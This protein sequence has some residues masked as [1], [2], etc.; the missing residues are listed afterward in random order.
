MTDYSERGNPDW[1]VQKT[2][3]IDRHIPATRPGV[4]QL[5]AKYYL[6][7]ELKCVRL[8]STSRWF[9][10][11]LMDQSMLNH[12]IVVSLNMKGCICH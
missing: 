9:N 2:D 12:N 10:G 5:L 4:V 7:G 1:L 11:D 3:T 8:E 6:Y